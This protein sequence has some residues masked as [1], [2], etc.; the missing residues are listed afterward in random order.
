ME[1]FL[2]GVE[3][4]TVDVAGRSFN[5]VKSGVIGLIG[6]S[7]KG[8]VNQLVL[9]TSDKDFAQFGKSLP[10]FNI[11]QS[12]EIIANQGAATVFV[13]NV[14]DSTAHTTAV[15]DEQKTVTNG[16]L[17]L[18]FAPI[19]A[20][21]IKDAGGQAVTY[22]SGTDYSIDEFGTFKV[23]SSQIANN[24]V[25]KFSYKKLNLSAVQASDL[26]GSR[27]SGTDV[28]TGS[29]LFELAYNT[30]G[31]TPK[32]FI[33]PLFST[34][35]AV[36]SLLQSLADKYRGIDYIDAPAAIP[37]NTAIAG[38]GPAGTIGF[39]ISHKRTELLYP[40]LLRYDAY[41]NTNI[42]FP[43]SAF[44]AGIRQAVDN[45]S[46][47]G[48]FWVSSSNRVINCQ[49]T[50]VSI[51]ASLNDGN[52]DNQVLNAAGIT[53]IFNTYG[54][55]IRTWGNRNSTFPADSSPLTFTNLVR[56][57]DIV[58]ETMELSALPYLD[59]GIDQ[60]FIDI[61]REDGNSFIRT[62]I[63][64]GALLPG[65]KI[66]YNKDDNSPS[67]LA[68]GKVVFERIYMGK[69]PAERITFKSIMDIT[70]LQNLK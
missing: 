42:A 28:R 44:L 31:F 36:G 17:K 5:I 55:G 3:T 11:P 61:V 22:Q 32:I 68:A 15:T 23:L 4:T 14:F 19:G 1:T 29:L 26:I 6:I 45:D 38:R 12:L 20:V 16:Q 66:V 41:S 53:T 2:H 48:G 18:G 50:D 52:A 59:R 40:Q 37:V 56:T 13:I 8:P 25:L 57:D 51:S 70:L 27:D 46:D 63:Q 47:N 10:G 30:Y 65:S 33:A 21:T 35:T 9:C 49:G 67:D 69:T 7:P 24:T 60:T 43:Y 62:L 39:N 34:I 58:S 54:T 64:R